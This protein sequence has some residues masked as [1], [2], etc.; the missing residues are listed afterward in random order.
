MVSDY[1][2]LT[3]SLFFF[4]IF[5]AAKEINTNIQYVMHTTYKQI[6]I[7]YKSY[8]ISFTTYI[9]IYHNKKYI[10]YII[11]YYECIIM[12]CRCSTSNR[13]Y[14]DI[15]ISITSVFNEYNGDRLNVDWFNKNMH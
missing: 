12:D 10:R 1:F 4:A 5:R 7:G 2:N 11:Q 8:S 15:F 6:S 9:C 13:G 14:I 3:V